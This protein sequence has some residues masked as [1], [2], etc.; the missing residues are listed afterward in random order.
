[1]D[2]KSGNPVAGTAGPPSDIAGETN[3]PALQPENQNVKFPPRSRSARKHIGAQQSVYSG[4]DRLGIVQ[5]IAV[6]WRAFGRRGQS[7][8]V[9]ETRSEAIDAIGKSLRGE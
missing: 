9:F 3:I 5:Q 6:G 8:G 4:Q 7:L 2:H 1:M